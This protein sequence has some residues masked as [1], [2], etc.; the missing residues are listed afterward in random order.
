MKSKIITLLLAVLFS[1]G[2]WLFVV[3]VEQPESENT[4]YDIPVIYQND[5]EA[6][7]KDRGLMIVSE[8]PTV[9]LKLKSTRTNLRNLNESNINIFVSLANITAAG[10]HKLNYSISYP[11]N[12]PSGE[13]S[14]VSASMEQISIKVEKRIT[15]PIPV[16][17][18]YLG[19]VPNGMIA[20]TEEVEL[21]NETIEVTGPESVMEKITQA[22][23][24]VDLEGQ[25]QTIAGEYPYTLCDEN[26]EPVDSALLTTNVEAVNLML[27]IQRVKEID[28]KVKVIAGGGA[29]EETSTIL[30]DPAK[31]R[32][33]GPEALLADLSY[34][35][36]GTIDL[37]AMTKAETMHFDI[38][39]PEGITNETGVTSVKVDVTFPNLLTRKI[40]VTNIQILNLPEGLEAELITESIELTIRGL[41]TQVDAIK[42]SDLTVTVD[43][44]DAQPGTFTKGVNV[45]IDPKYMNVGTMGTYS[46]SVT[47]QEATEEE[48]K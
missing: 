29:T 47:V 13:V 42:D 48:T 2:L 4:Y 38:V 6:L 35:E 10:N 40:P 12:I 7:L 14:V 27:K 37:G 25:T 17:P 23:I 41:A 3:T 22:V 33:S 26:G 11:G 39:L 30:I 5:G 19:S 34:L 21:D 1:C 18:V 9:T 15:K 8:R 46:V 43:L 20:H 31:I 32:V 16:A 44:A 36:I 28:L 24:Q 45:S